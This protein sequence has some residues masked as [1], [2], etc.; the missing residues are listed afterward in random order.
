M[1]K[2]AGATGAGADSISRSRARGQQSDPVLA[3]VSDGILAEGS[4]FGVYVIGPCIGRGGMA[5]VYRAEHGGLRRQ[6]ALKMLTRGF[7]RDASGRERFLREAC[8]AAA[9]RH[10]NVVSIFDVGLH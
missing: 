10:P 7:E 8:I 2:R 5:C 1:S 6:V 9:I 4:R 3:D